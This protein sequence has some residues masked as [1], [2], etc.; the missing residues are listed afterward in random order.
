MAVD[1][2][3]ALREQLERGLTLPAS[4]Y[5]DPEV[6]RLEQE[7]IFG[8]TWQYAGSL[9][10]LEEPGSYITCRAGATPIVVVRRPGGR[11]AAGSSTSAA[12]AATRSRRAAAAARRCSAPTTPGRTTSTARSVR[13]RARSGSPGST[14]PTGACGRCSS[15]RGG[16]SSSSTPTST[17]PRSRRHSASCRRRW[18]TAGS[19]PSTLEYHGRS[20]DWVIDA[21]WKLV[22]ENFLECYHCP[23]AHKSFSRLIDVDPDSY[24]LTTSRWTLEPVR[25]GHRARRTSFPYEPIGEVRASQFHYVWPNWT[26]NTLPRAGRTSACSS[27]TRSTPSGRRRSST[28]S[29]RPARA[30]R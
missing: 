6:L 10:Q 13:R 11:P 18:P 26:L 24:R 8:R 4:W 9:T 15:T 23:V 17:P 12:T 5:S 1:T 25:P 27:S 16:R 2:T 22:V 29:G 7:R 3:P 14:A 21:N 30:R 28:A 19:T 20:R